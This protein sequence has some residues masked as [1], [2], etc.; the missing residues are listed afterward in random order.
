MKRKILTALAWL[1]LTTGSAALAEQTIYAVWA[2]PQEHRRSTLHYAAGKVNGNWTAP[3]QLSL[4]RGLH[5]TPVIAEDRKRNIWIVWVEQTEEENI[6]RYAVVRQGGAKVGR[7]NPAGK[8]QSYAPTILIDRNDV[9]WIAWSGVT[10][11]LADIYTGRWNGTGWE[12]RVMV[13]AANQTPD[14]MPLLGLHQGKNTVW[15][16]WFGISRTEERYVRYHAEWEKDAWRVAEKTSPTQG[17][18]EFIR[19]RTNTEIQFPQQAGQWL[20]GAVFT[21]L[22]DEIQSVSE[23]F[24]RFRH[25]GEHDAKDR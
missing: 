8:E 3:V 4:N 15:V 24:A 18:K 25:I 7:I 20:T 19:Q 1:L 21:G 10:G 17:T 16:D 22:D 11:R 9:P 5:I 12:K 14:I 2:R 6:L 13:H 23:R